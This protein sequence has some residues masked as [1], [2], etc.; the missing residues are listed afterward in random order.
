MGQPWGD[1]RRAHLPAGT[2]YRA[3]AHKR[4]HTH[5]HSPLLLTLD[6]LQAQRHLLPKEE[7]ARNLPSPPT[8]ATANIH[9]DSKAFPGN[10]GSRTAPHL[11][12]SQPRFL[13]LKRT[14]HI[15]FFCKE[16]QFKQRVAHPFKSWS[17]RL[18]SLAHSGG[19]FATAPRSKDQR[20]GVA[21]GR[22][23]VPALTV[24]RARDKENE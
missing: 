24:P 20:Q 22:K 5:T 2:S 4:A 1:E 9:R 7:A 8:W 21:G 19:N 16:L 6:F 18:P 3:S 12:V 23:Q 17:P 11:L 13:L 10:P 15:F 14:S